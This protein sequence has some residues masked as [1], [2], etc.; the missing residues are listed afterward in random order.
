MKQIKLRENTFALVD[1]EDFEYLNQYTWSVDH[2]DNN[3]N[4]Y[5]KSRINGQQVS[6]HRLIMGC[7][8]GDG[9]ILDHKDGNG[10]NNQK[11]NLRFCTNSQNQKNK[12]ASGSSKYLGVYVRFTKSGLTWVS[13]IK[14]GNKYICLGSFKR[15]ESAA[16]AYN[17][18]ALKY[19]GE[20]ARPNIIIKNNR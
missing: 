17:R 19:H 10:L 9:K 16:K 7:K 11:S 14:V 3:R 13:K 2:L 5:A 1:D 4:Q 15:E 8:N 6:M 18:A 20:F 12:R